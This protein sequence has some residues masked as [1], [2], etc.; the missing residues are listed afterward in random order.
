MKRTV[1]INLICSFITVLVI[2]LGIIFVITINGDSDLFS[3]PKLVISSEGA[4]V[5]YNGKTLV[6]GKWHLA[7]GELKNGHKLSV[8]VSGAQTEVGISDNYV[9]AKVLDQNGSDVT[10]QYKIDYVPGALNVKPRPITITAKSAEKVYDGTPLTC[11]DYEVSAMSLLDGHHLSVTI[12]G[13]ITE[14]GT[15]PNMI[16]GVVINDDSGAD[17]TKNYSVKVSNGTLTVTDKRLGDGVYPAPEDGFSI[18]LPHGNNEQAASTV[19]F[20]VNST[21]EGNIYLKERSY[22]AYTG[23]GFAKAE[24]YSYRLYNS[25]SA[26]YLT[27]KAIENGGGAYSLM[28]IDPRYGIFAIPYQASEMGYTLQSSDVYFAGSTDSPYNVYYFT[29]LDGAELPMD[30]QEFE[31]QYRSHVYASYTAVP[32][33]TLEYLEGIIAEQGFD[34]S[35]PEIISKVAQYVKG[36]ASYSIYYNRDL[37][38]SEDIVVAFLDL[39]K[40]GIC[41]HYAAAATMLYRALGIPARFTVGYATDI[42]ANVDANVTGADAHAWVEV[43]INGLGWVHVEVTGGRTGPGV[44]D[45]EP[46]PGPEDP[47]VPD[48]PPDVPTPPVNP[49]AFTV[50]AER[51]GKIY[52]KMYSLGDYSKENAGFLPAVEY[53]GLINGS[54][55]AY[56]L[57]AYALD[58]GALTTN[59]VTVTPKLN[60]FAMPYYAAPGYY[61]QTSDVTMSGSTASSYTVPYYAWTG[62][63]GV[64]IPNRLSD[65]E[66][67]YAEFVRANYLEVDEETAEF[68]RGIIQQKNFKID[69]SNIINKVAKYIQGSAKYN[70]QYDTA[71]DSEENFVIAFLSTY[72]EGVCR[73]Y[74]AAATMLFRTLGIPA[75]YTE[76]FLADAKAG[77]E[78]DVKME[79]AHA[80]VEVYVD[81]IGWVIVEVTGGSSSGTTDKKN[82]I[83]TPVTTREEYVEGRTLYALNAVSGFTTLE[84]EGYTYIAEIDGFVEG[85]GKAVS[86]VTEFEIYSPDGELVYKYSTGFGTDKFNVQYQTG[87][88]HQYISEVRFKSEDSAKIYDGVKLETLLTECYWVSGDLCQSLGYTYTITPTGSISKAGTASSTY[89][90]KFYKNGV[91]CTDHFY[92]RNTYGTLTLTAREITISAKSD[93]KAYDGSAL[94]CDGIDCDETLLAPGDRIDHYVVEG[95]QTNIGKSANVLVSVKIVNELGVDVT[96]NYKITIQDGILT[97][98]VPT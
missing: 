6:N 35:D 92:I 27:S 95:T 28:T 22:G 75:R 62:T 63:A 42:E 55:S 72:K 54:Y 50:L 30:L 44:P 77:V 34:P 2:A 24:D 36:A 64:V 85:L 81:N 7:S 32:A 80:W 94:T 58:N 19:V 76:G 84:R 73:H 93:T 37:D 23:R 71:L 56:Y 96:D 46:G 65:Y 18:G 15:T 10:S 97:V 67:A 91:D 26:Y 53:D 60:Y 61:T 21:S 33:T 9:F 48:I 4:T 83:I 51:T 52:L 3:N 8:E 38:K 66:D 31:A 29:S 25:F 5:E 78:V 12:E 41:Q 82:L 70:L 11:N 79:S 45:P 90:V 68:M 59:S 20:V 87:T 89:T 43:Y 86:R 39:Y 49:V 16:K 1:L 74:A 14:I 47:P 17:V 98:T 40:S 57:P 69:D 88:V 13:S